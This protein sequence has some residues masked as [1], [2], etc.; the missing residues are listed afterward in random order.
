M[1]RRSRQDPSPKTIRSLP[2]EAAP[3]KR[4]PDLAHLHAL[5]GIIQGGPARSYVLLATLQNCGL[6]RARGAP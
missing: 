3:T 6:P 1:K 5:Q 2:I 4:P